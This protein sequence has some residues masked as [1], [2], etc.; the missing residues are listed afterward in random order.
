MESYKA[1]CRDSKTNVWGV[2][3]ESEAEDGFTKVELIVEKTKPHWANVIAAALN[4][5]AQK[6]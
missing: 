6:G 5:N 3:R 1:V 4:H 2:I